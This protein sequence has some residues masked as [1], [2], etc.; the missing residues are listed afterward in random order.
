MKMTR[1]TLSDYGKD[2]VEKMKGHT[3]GD[4]ADILYLDGN[5]PLIV[6]R[7]RDF[8]EAGCTRVLSLPRDFGRT[9]I[10]IAKIGE[11]ERYIVVNIVESP[12]S[13]EQH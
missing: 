12:E 10:Y 6:P 4:L 5:A 1:R 3:R 11:V 8:N 7:A 2:I 13:K 9:T